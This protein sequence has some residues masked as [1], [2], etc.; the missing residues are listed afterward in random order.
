MVN[1]VQVDETKKIPASMIEG[2]VAGGGTI[3]LQQG[4]NIQIVETNPGV[5]EISTTATTNDTDAELRDRGTHTGTDAITD[6]VGLQ[7]A[8][9]SKIEALAGTTV[10]RTFRYSSINDARPTTD[11]TVDIRWIP[12]SASL[13]RPVNALGTDEVVLVLA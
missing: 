12:T 5:F 10:P 1:L 8:L 3:T 6:I 9:N 2:I 13:G 7:E 11:P 4:T